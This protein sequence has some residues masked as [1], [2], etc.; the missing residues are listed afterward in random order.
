MRRSIG[1][2]LGTT[3]SVVASNAQVLPLVD[4]KQSSLLLPSVV[5]FLPN[6]GAIIGEEARL[7]RP[8]DPINTIYSSKRLMGE[9]WT[10][11]AARQ[12]Q[13]QYPHNLSACADGHVQFETRAG[14]IKPA[15]VAALIVSHLCM[16]SM[17]HP[18]DLHAVVTVPSS[19]REAARRAT[20]LALQHAGL[21]DVR[22][23]EEPVATALAYL[24]RSNL[25]YAAVYDLGG[26]TFDL[27]IVDCS[28]FPFRVLGHGGD[29]YLGGDDI[30]RALADI[31][32]EKVLRSAGWDLKSE[33]VTYAR[34]TLAVE[35][36]KC[37][38]AT[39]SETSIDIT[40][41]DP[42]AP[43]VLTQVSVD[44]AMLESAAVPFIRR[45][46]GICD[47]VLSEVKLHARDLQ[48]TFLA[49]GSTRLP[50]L[51]SMLS[52]YFSRRVRSDIDPEHVVAIGASM[53]AARPKLWP[54]LEAPP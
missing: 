5:S 45:T 34:L 29:A 2:D 49:G 39:R 22:L 43:P 31:V 35:R 11:Y 10:S 47:E 16:R 15:G 23:I 53:T 6:G 36:A 19:F 25:R 28:S 21:S 30:D 8:L 1:I 41:V 26:G 12:F 37:E 32:V 51:G 14:A 54:L 50:M 42:A 40:Q 52:E 17:E 24:Q 33:P 48:A 20:T 7:R 18:T 3:N 38:L 13:T 9:G 27:A 4:G 46:F 44:R